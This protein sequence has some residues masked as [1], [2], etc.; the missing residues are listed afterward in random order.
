MKKKHFPSEKEN[1]L[2]KSDAK[3]IKNFCLCSWLL[4]EPLSCRKNIV[5]GRITGF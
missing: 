3:D 2:F 4:K 5:V 1:I